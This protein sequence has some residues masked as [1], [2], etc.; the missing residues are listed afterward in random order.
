M[1]VMPL[2]SSRLKPVPQS[3][4]TPGQTAASIKRHHHK[5]PQRQQ[6]RQR[7]GEVIRHQS[8]EIRHQ[9][10]AHDGHD[11]KRAAAFGVRAEVFHAHGEDRR[12][13]DRHEEEHRDQ[14]HHR[15]AFHA[16]DH[17]C[18]QRDVSGGLAGHA[19]PVFGD[20]VDKE[21]AH[22]HLRRDVEELCDHAADELAVLPERLAVTAL[23]ARLLLAQ[24]GHR[25][26]GKQRG[27]QQHNHGD[28]HVGGLQR[29]VV[30]AGIAAAEEQCAAE[31]W[32]D[33]LPQAVERLRQ[34]QSPYDRPHRKNRL[35]TSINATR[36][37][38][39]AVQRDEADV[40]LTPGLHHSANLQERACPRLRAERRG[41]VH[42]H[43]KPRAQSPDL[44]VKH[45]LTAQ[46]L[47]DLRPDAPVHP[48]VFGD[49]RRVIGQVQGHAQ[50]LSVAVIG[51]VTAR[52]AAHKQHAVGDFRRRGHAL[53]ERD[54]LDNLCQL[55]LWVFKA[56]NPAFVQRRHDLG[57]DYRV[58]A[59]A[60]GQQRSGPLPGQRQ[61]PS[62]GCGVAAGAAL[63]GE[64]GFRADVDDGAFAGLQRIDAHMRHDVVMNE[65]LLQRLDKRATAGLQP[66]VVID[67][68][69][70]DQPVEAPEAF[71]HLAHRRHASDLVAQLD[72]HEQRLRL[73]SV[74]FGSQLGGQRLVGEDHR[75][76]AFLRQ[77][78]RDGRAD[79]RAAAGHDEH[80]VLQRVLLSGGEAADGGFEE[81]VDLAVTA[82]QLA[83]RP[84]GAEHQPVR[85]E[86]L[87]GQVE[88]GQQFHRPP[89]L[90]VCFGDQAAQLAGNMGQG[91]QRGETVSPGDGVFQGQ[92]RRA[93]RARARPEQ[94]SETPPVS[95]RLPSAPAARQGHQ[96]ANQPS[97]PRR[98]STGGWWHG[99]AV[100][101]SRQGSAA[102]ARQCS[103]RRRAGPAMASNHPA[104]NPVATAHGARQ[105]TG[106]PVA[107]RSRNAGEHPPARGMPERLSVG[108]TLLLYSVR[109]MPDAS[110]AE[111]RICR[112]RLAGEPDVP[113]DSA[114]SGRTHSRASALLQ[115]S[116]DV[117]SLCMHTAPAKR[118]SSRSKNPARWAA[119]TPRRGS[120]TGRRSARAGDR[121]TRPRGPHGCPRCTGNRSS[122]GAHLV[123]PAQAAGI[124]LHH[125]NRLTHDQ[126][127]EDNAVL[128]HFARGHLHRL[129]PETNGTVALDVVRAGGFFDEPRRGEGQFA[130]PVNGLVDL[131]D[132]IGI[133]HQMTLRPQHLAGDAHAADVVLQVA[134]DLQFDMGKTTVHRLLTQAPQFVVRVT[135]PSGRR[136]VAGVTVRHQRLHTLRLAL[137]T[138]GQQRQGLVRRDAIGDVAKIDAAHQLLRG[139]LGHQL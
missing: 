9:R 114:A 53:A 112:S 135:Q 26:A 136:G 130:D 77:P 19:G 67:A 73:A 16:A 62:F 36:T 109:F 17:H 12:E 125:V 95:A 96:R 90:P 100:R 71:E 1:R 137:G 116:G 120:R 75:Y 82:G 58:D 118:P 40:R 139:H 35:V 7:C 108:T 48:L 23:E 59:H 56:G 68:G 29:T 133:D 10:A 111:A 34:V 63:A 49:Q 47:G 88:I 69:V 126:L 8:H 60:V 122:T 65:V 85:T 106:S 70:I 132:L 14:R 43:E 3:R 38:G 91:G 110:S 80:F 24:V 72:L 57:R 76:G 42:D 127:L 6:V 66:H 30:A 99:R 83:N 79:P 134:A 39:A 5:T 21:R 44:H 98:E 81:V 31:Q 113:G 25:R 101:P 61:L 74:Q 54:L 11:Q 92:Q 50:T 105:S 15:H 64:G 78:Q 121:R 28:D 33:E 4:L 102:P 103:R 97:P 13:H 22:A 27:D 37:D 86:Q 117:L 84:V 129:D 124:D 131:P 119:C 128:A 2:A 52:I 32:P 45:A 93:E 18:T 94:D 51:Q 55:G 104:G 138:F 87:E 20:V 115:G 46:V 107:C 123:D 89:V 41:G